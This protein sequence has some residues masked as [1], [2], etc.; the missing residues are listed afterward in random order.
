MSQLSSRYRSANLRSGKGRKVFAAEPTG[1]LSNDF[2]GK[3]EVRLAFTQGILCFF[4][5]NP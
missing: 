2:V 1:F 3:V 5:K 4:G